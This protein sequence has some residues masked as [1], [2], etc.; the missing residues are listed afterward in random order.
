V[1]AGV[2]AAQLDTVSFGKEMPVCTEHDV[3]IVAEKTN[4]HFPGNLLSVAYLIGG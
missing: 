2:S 1:D 4:S 3:H